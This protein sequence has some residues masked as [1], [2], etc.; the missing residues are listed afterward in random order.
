[1]DLGLKS[2]DYFSL[3]KCLKEDVQRQQDREKE[4]QQR[5]ADLMMEKETLQA[6]F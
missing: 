1:M 2:R 6:K 3:F 5:Y 4:L